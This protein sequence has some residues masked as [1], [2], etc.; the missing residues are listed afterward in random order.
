MSQKVSD[1][2]LREAVK[3][4]WDV[5]VAKFAGELSESYAA[6]SS[7]FSTTAARAEPGRLAAMRRVREYFDPVTKMK[8]E[9]GPIEAHVLDET[10]GVAYYTFRL[11]ASRKQTGTGNQ[12][13]EEITNGRGTQVFQRSPEGKLLILHEHL[14][15]TTPEK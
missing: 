6:G 13:E 11:H 14:S 15:M 4:F 2:E 7:V 9:L 5:M 12:I 1:E 8:V 3:R 10:A